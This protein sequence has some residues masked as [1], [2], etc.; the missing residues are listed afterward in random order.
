MYKADIKKQ[1]RI[2]YVVYC[3]PDWLQVIKWKGMHMNVAID[4]HFSTIAHLGNFWLYRY[5]YM[6]L[7]LRS[8][9]FE[10]ITCSIPMES[11]CK[12]DCALARS[13]Q[14]YGTF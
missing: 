6:Y 7:S 9:V 12:M 14:W 13:L 10:C 5:I 2:I 1:L 8:R 4:Q 3:T 11:S